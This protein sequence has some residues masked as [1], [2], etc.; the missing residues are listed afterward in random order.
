MQAIRAGVLGRLI[1]ASVTSGSAYAQDMTRSARLLAVFAVGGTLLVTGC[2]NAIDTP[3]PPNGAVGISVNAAGDPIGI[4]EVCRS[5]VDAIEMSGQISD[6]K[7]ENPSLGRWTATA[8]ITGSAVLDFLHPGPKWT[9]TLQPR[10]F[11]AHRTHIVDN[12]TSAKDEDS[13][14]SQGT[15]TL[16]QV[17]KLTNKDVLVPDGPTNLKVIPRP[18]FRGLTCGTGAGGGY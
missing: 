15:F 14:L 16:E 2:G 6:E 7:S 17:A 11:E 3:P 9:A 10:S 1:A 8:P 4:I 18:T 5:S 12:L 13:V